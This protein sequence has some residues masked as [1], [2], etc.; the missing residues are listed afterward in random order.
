MVEQYM[1]YMCSRAV[2]SFLLT[3]WVKSTP[4]S[5]P[6][7]E[8]TLHCLLRLKKRLYAVDNMTTTLLQ[9]DYYTT[10]SYT[11]LTQLRGWF[12]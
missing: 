2:K 7:S 9:H 1:T 3:E 12:C 10:A 11:R 8:G 5:F 4:S 6:R